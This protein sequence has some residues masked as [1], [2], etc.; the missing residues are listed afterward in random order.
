MPLPTGKSAKLKQIWPHVHAALPALN[1]RAPFGAHGKVGVIGGSG[2]NAGPAFFAA[3]AALRTGADSATVLTDATA[4][5]LVAGYTPEVSVIEVVGAEDDAE[6][7]REKI[8]AQLA[9]I[10]VLVVGNGLAP[11]SAE[12][13]G[14]ICTIMTVAAKRD[15]GLPTVVDGSIVTPSMLRSLSNH[16]KAVVIPTQAEFDALSPGQSDVKTFSWNNGKLCVMVSG[17]AEKLTDGTDVFTADEPGCHAKTKGQRDV[18]AGVLGS[19]LCWAHSNPG[20]AS[21]NMVA[22][23]AASTIT[24][25]ASYLAFANRGRGV[26]T[27][28]IIDNIPAAMDQFFPVTPAMPG[29]PSIASPSSS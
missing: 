22:C 28:D 20:D 27:M 23:A 4:A 11:M 1:G 14:A 7:I 19:F 6:M 5:A 29:S 12:V 18:L 26:S 9:D 24:R 13:E 16:P 25:R 17:R 15:G 10:S 21:A 2:L 3:M 8:T